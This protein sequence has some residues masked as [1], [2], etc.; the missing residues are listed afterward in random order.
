MMQQP[1]SIM[2][3]AISVLLS[4]APSLHQV[5]LSHKLPIYP[6]TY[7]QTDEGKG[8]CDY[9]NSTSICKLTEYIGLFEWYYG[10]R[11]CLTWNVM[12]IKNWQKK[13]EK[14]NG[15]WWMCQPCRQDMKPKNNRETNKTCLKR[16]SQGEGS[17]QSCLRNKQLGQQNY[18]LSLTAYSET[19]TLRS[20]SRDTRETYP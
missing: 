1:A 9:F 14:K 4:S 7:P 17:G 10:M 12:G 18:Q 20:L 15:H 11:K 19:W 2:H 3:R 16:L 8:K 5:N 13:G 6:S